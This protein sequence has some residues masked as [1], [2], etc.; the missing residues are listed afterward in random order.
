M[1]AAERL[2]AAGRT[3]GAEERLRRVVRAAERRALALGA[4]GAALVAALVFLALAAERG[5]VQVLP[6][7]LAALVLGLCL[8]L[9]AG[10]AVLLARRPRTAA[11]E[12]ARVPRS[13]D[14]AEAASALAAGAGRP[15]T[16]PLEAGLLA[17][18]V[19]RALRRERP[20]KEAAGASRNGAPPA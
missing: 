10:V 20:G 4:A 16:D 11:R 14:L 13:D 1:S 6:P 8:L 3:R 18:A 15:A 5:L 19:L 7:A 9:V 17:A 12:A 2:L